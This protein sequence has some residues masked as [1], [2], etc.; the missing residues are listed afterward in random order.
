MDEKI[1]K[2]YDDKFFACRDIGVQ[3]RG[4]GFSTM[5]P[6]RPS[7]PTVVIRSANLVAFGKARRHGPPARFKSEGDHGRGDRVDQPE[8]SNTMVSIKVKK[9]SPI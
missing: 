3:R 4:P 6:A 8:V 2:I 5:S 9:L 7:V 1:P